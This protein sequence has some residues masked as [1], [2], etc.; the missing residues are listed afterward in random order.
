[1][2]Y[3]F[4]TYRYRE[5]EKRR[6]LYIIQFVFTFLILINI[7]CYY[8]LINN[9]NYLTSIKKGISYLS[10]KKFSSNV[11]Y[12]KSIDLECLDSLNKFNKYIGVNIDRCITI[13]VNGEKTDAS[14]AVND[15]VDY[16]NI[17]KNIENNHSLK[18]LKL[19]PVVMNSDGK[20]IFEISV[21]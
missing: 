3:N 16:E 5:K 1:M 11:K 17:I 2:E 14:I 6:I 8:N 21:R 19:S 13:E 10:Q 15:L 4:L 7:F 20:F 18:I 9:I 12:N